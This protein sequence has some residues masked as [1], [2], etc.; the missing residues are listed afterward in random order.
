MLKVAPVFGCRLCGGKGTV[1]EDKVTC[2]CGCVINQIPRE[3]ID[4]E[5]ELTTQDKAYFHI[6]KLL[7]DF[8]TKEPKK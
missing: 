1:V 3:L 2:L 8:Y 6:G 4:E 7:I 5:V